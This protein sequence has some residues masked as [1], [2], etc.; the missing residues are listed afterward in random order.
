MRSRSSVA[1]YAADALLSGTVPREQLIL[2]L[3]AWLKDTKYSRQA[4]YLINDIAI[5]LAEQGY[6]YV[7]ITT[8]HPLS[9]ETRQAVMHFIKDHYP[10]TAN[11]QIELQ[12]RID[13][14]LVGG[15]LIDTPHGS[16]DASV[17]RKLMHI[18]KGVQG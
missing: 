17:K 18:V 11:L 1:Q 6:I 4:A 5:K 12:E 16:L 15:V 14:S 13:A 2:Q 9:D 7:T 3:A 10:H 8:A